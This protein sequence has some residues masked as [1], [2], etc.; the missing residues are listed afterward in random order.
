MVPAT[1][2]LYQELRGW[3]GEE[4]AERLDAARDHPSLPR[5]SFEVA[6]RRWGAEAS[7]TGCIAYVSL[8]EWGDI[9]YDKA[10]LWNDGQ[11]VLADTNLQA[12]LEYFRS[13]AGLDLG[14]SPIDLERYR[15]EDAAEK[16][17]ALACR[18]E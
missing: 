16:W 12:A 2:R 8:G 17:A 7:R 11:A 14:D 1:A 10:T 5:P 13:Q 9:G 6:A 18:S 4:E 3:L 15:G